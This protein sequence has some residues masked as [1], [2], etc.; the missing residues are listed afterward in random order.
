MDESHL[1][2]ADAQ[3]NSI[4]ESGISRARIM[5]KAPEGFE[6]DCVCGAE[7]PPARVTA[8]YFNCVPCQEKL[9]RHIKTHRGGI[10]PD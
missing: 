8:G 10:A 9:E 4:I 7:I 3:M 6:G 5:R 1:E 2:L